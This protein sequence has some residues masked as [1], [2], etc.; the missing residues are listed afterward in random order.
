M[1]KTIASQ[2][3]VAITDTYY[4]TSDAYV[5]TM[6]DSG[7]KPTERSKEWK[8]LIKDYQESGK[9][10]DA[11]SNLLKW[12]IQRARNPDTDVSLMSV[13]FD[14]TGNTEH[15]VGCMLTLAFAIAAH[16][17]VCS[18]ESRERVRTHNTVSQWLTQSEVRD[19]RPFFGTCKHL[20]GRRLNAYS[21]LSRSVCQR[22][23]TGRHR[24]GRGSE[25]HWNRSRQLLLWRF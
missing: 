17:S 21:M 11:Y 18:L 15:D 9:C 2:L 4:L 19:K 14:T 3:A 10:D 25:R 12:T 8:Q 5:A 6:E 20:L 13:E 7:E 23:W 24:S 1:P 22:R 16:P